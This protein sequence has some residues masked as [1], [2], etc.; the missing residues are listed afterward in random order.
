MWQYCCRVILSEV[1][2][3][4]AKAARC[5]IGHS[6]DCQ[7]ERERVACAVVP[8]WLR[9]VTALAATLVVGGAAVCA[10]VVGH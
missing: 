7:T 8:F 10:S 4:A 1:R 9:A 2:D 3:P 5:V 6:Y